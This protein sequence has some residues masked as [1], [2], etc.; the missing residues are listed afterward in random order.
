MPTLLNFIEKV[1]F[2]DMPVVI[3]PPITLIE[4]HQYVLHDEYAGPSALESTATNPRTA[5]IDALG[6]DSIYISIVLYMAAPCNNYGYYYIYE[7][8]N[9]DGSDATLLRYLNPILSYS[10]NWEFFVRELLNENIPLTKR[11]VKLAVLIPYYQYPGG[12]D[13]GVLYL[14]QIG[15]ATKVVTVRVTTSQGYVVY[16]TTIKVLDLGN[17]AANRG[18]T[19][20]N[21]WVTINLWTGDQKIWA[22]KTI[23]KSLLNMSAKD[24]S[25]LKEINADT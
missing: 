2:T 20:K 3:V 4:N 8:N 23:N 12:T 25:E 17:N 19:D 24:I 18:T 1:I 10:P 7:S 13:S 21:G 16:G 9:S 5:I 14:R 11:Y 22:E 6:Y 15:L